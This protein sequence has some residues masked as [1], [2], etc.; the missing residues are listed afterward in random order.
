M[1]LGYMRLS[2]PPKD[3]LY[4]FL[5][6]SNPPKDPHQSI[7][8]VSFAAQRRGAGGAF[9]DYTARYGAVR[10]EDRLT[11]RETLFADDTSDSALAQLDLLAERLDLKNLLDL[12][13]IVLSNGQT[14]RA[15]I[16]K[17]LMSRPELLLL[18]E[19]LSKLTL[20]LLPA[21]R[22]NSF[23]LVSWPRYTAPT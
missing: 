20:S 11:L 19:P 15:R 9:Y 23:L 18:D 16:A 6:S 1:L 22:S 12:P 2:P 10:D 4:P 5:F 8:L 21:Q 13:F 14:R 3:G 7:A 17:A